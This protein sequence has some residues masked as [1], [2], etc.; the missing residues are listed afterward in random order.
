M[1][2]RNPYEVRDPAELRRCVETSTRVTSHSTRSLAKVTGFSQTTIGHLMTG[3][4]KRVTPELAQRL[5]AA[6]GRSVSDL[7]MPTVSS[8]ADADNGSAEAPAEP[9]Q[10]ARAGQSADAPEGDR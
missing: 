7:F 10:G 6:L 1:R 9:M 2:P 4:K 5:S 3:R 8:S